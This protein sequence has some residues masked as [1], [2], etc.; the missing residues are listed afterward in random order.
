[1]RCRKQVL[2]WT[3]ARLCS[4]QAA[5]RWT[6]L[7][8]A[9][10]WQRWLV[11]PRVAEVLLPGSPTCTRAAHT[12]SRPSGLWGLSARV[13]SPT[14]ARRTRGTSPGAMLARAA[15]ASRVARTPPSARLRRQHRRQAAGPRGVTFG[16]PTFSHD[17]G[18]RICGRTL[19]SRRRTSTGASELKD[20]D[21]AATQPAV[22]PEGIEVGRL[23]CATVGQTAQ[24]AHPGSIRRSMMA[25]SSYS[26]LTSW[27]HGRASQDQGCSRFL[28]SRVARSLLSAYM[29]AAAGD[30]P[31]QPVRRSSA[32]R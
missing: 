9:G 24:P 30:A 7:L 20:I 22:A 18:V 1:L 5:N 16:C 19:K 31:S 8:A 12:R 4:P 27:P 6:R 29:P 26:L 28:P 3:T 21:A 2:G 25:T 15:V 23:T 32:C 13:N 11:G 10:L 14:R 17:V